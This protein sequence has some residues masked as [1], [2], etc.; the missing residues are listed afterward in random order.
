MAMPVIERRWTVGNALT[1][2]ALALQGL[3]LFGGGVWFYSHTVTNIQT[4]FESIQRNTLEISKVEN[5]QKDIQARISFSEAQ[6]G[7]MDERLIAMQAVLMKI[8]RQME[9]LTP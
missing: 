6:Y 5:A 7:R 2:A 8:D 3:A 1:I 9:R 4:N